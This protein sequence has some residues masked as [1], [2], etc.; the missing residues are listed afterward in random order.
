MVTEHV[1]A[2]RCAVKIRIGPEEE[3]AFENK[4]LTRL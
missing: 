3:I 1:A 2:A 4:D